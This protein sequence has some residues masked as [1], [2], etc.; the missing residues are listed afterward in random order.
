MMKT[1]LTI[2]KTI[3]LPPFLSQHQDEDTCICMFSM[4][5]CMH[6]H[7]NVPNQNNTYKFSEK[8]AKKDAFIS[9]YCCLL[10]TKRQ[11]A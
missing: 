2:C 11:Y 3:L 9:L 7:D 6:I 5:A 4:H 8:Q 1:T 10:F